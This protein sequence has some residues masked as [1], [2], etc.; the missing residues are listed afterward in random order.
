M[1]PSM[2]NAAAPYRGWGRCP[3]TLVAWVMGSIRWT[4]V[5]A[6]G[7]LAGEAICPPKA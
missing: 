5:V 3:T 1:L 7:A 6:A 2:S 4:S